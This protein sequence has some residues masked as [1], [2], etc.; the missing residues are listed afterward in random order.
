VW[1]RATGTTVF[2]TV[3]G[4]SDDL[5]AGNPQAIGGGNITVH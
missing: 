3:P 2:D 4:G 1:E 5:D